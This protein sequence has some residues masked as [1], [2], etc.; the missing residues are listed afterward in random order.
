MPLSLVAYKEI[1]GNLFS[2]VGEFHARNLS[3]LENGLRVRQVTSFIPYSQNCGP[4]CTAAR[5]VEQS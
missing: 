4:R 2:A 5:H 3:Y 1:Q